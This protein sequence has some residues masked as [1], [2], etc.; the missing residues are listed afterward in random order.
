MNPLLI[1]FL[2][3]NIA[4]ALFYLF[5]RLFF[6]RDTFLKTRRGYLLASIVLSFIY[7]FLNITGW[8]EN[9]AP[10]QQAL[11]GFILLNEVTITPE[12]SGIDVETLIYSMYGL[13][14]VFLLIRLVIQFISI[15]R[16]KRKGVE[17]ML[18]DTRIV[19]LKSEIA[20]FSFFG[21][22]YMNPE[23]HTKSETEQILTH[24]TTHVKQMH[25]IDVIFTE[26]LSIICWINPAAWLMKRE[27]RQNL[28]FLADNKVIE[29]GFD[30]KSYQYHLL[31]LA[32]Q[33]PN[34]KLTN[35]FNISPLKKR[36]TMMNQ[37]KSS[38]TT[39]FKYLM[40]APLIAAL[41]ITSNFEALASSAKNLLT[42]Q[43]TV[44]NSE[45]TATSNVQTPIVADNNQ[46]STTTQPAPD[47]KTPSPEADIQDDENEVFM[48]VE[49]MPEY[50]GGQEAMMKFLMNNVKYPTDAVKDN[51]Q[52]RVILQ[53]VVNQDGSVSD[54]VV[55]RGVSSS[56]DAEAI[57]VIKAMPKWIPG[58][59]KG[60]AVRVKY[61]MPINFKLDGDTKIIKPLVIVDG[62]E[63]PAG[64]DFSTIKAEDIEKIDVLKDAS[65]TATYGEKGKNGVVIITMKKK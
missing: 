35:K 39:A 31:Q 41:I 34:V 61:T 44:Q 3:V 13:V 29:S 65:A 48:V 58:T 8:L 45:K 42:E 56:L 32:Y 18:Q 62:V 38:K 10:V 30:S 53:F 17:I 63:K 64:F 57:R 6:V 28:E 50:P 36:I 11:S 20:P 37:K 14:S 9:Q 60:K 23:L 2:K 43:P 54:V 1:Y 49:K 52:G 55:V 46:K 22:I 59:Q 5:Y 25:S 51:I 12:N 47:K 4:I 26:M 15:L 21:K 40:V 7:P 33:S 24:E 19:A 16:M 27:V